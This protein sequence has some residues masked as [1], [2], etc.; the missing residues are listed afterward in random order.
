MRSLLG[1][2]L[3]QK[4]HTRH[5]PKTAHTMSW[6][7]RNGATLTPTKVSSWTSKSDHFDIATGPAQRSRRRSPQFRLSLTGQSLDFCAFFPGPPPGALQNAH[8]IQAVRRVPVTRLAY[9]SLPKSLAPRTRC[10]K[11]FLSWPEPAVS[12]PPRARNHAISRLS[13]WPFPL[14]HYPVVAFSWG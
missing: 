11:P 2:R 3:H 5:T 9:F 10:C 4:R 14:S 8:A 12:P 1:P 13:R 7:E 6:R